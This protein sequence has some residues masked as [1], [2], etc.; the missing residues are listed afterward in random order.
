MHRSKPLRF[1][2]RQ[3]IRRALRLTDFRHPSSWPTQVAV[4]DE[5]LILAMRIPE[6]SFTPDAVEQAISELTRMHA[7]V[8]EGY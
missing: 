3:K 1:N 4:R 2:A 8:A 5:H 7:S 6:R